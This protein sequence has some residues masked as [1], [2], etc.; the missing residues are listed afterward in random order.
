MASESSASTKASTAPH[1]ED[2]R[3]PGTPTELDGRTWKYVLGKAVSEFSRDQCTLLAAALTYYGVLSLFPALLAVVSLLGVFGQGESTTN[4]ILD[5]INRFGS[6]S[7]AD[8]LEGPISNMVNASGAGIGLV[9]GLLGALWSASGYV[10]AFGKAMNTIY[11]VDEGRPIWKLRPQMLLVTAG[12]VVL[13][14]LLALGLVVSGG[15]ADAIGSVIGLGDT[16]VMVWGI[17]KWPVMLLL[18]VVM[19]ASLYYFTPNVRHPAFR[20]VTPGAAVAIL[21]AILATVA[22]G[23][24]VA[25]FSSYNATYG[26]LAGVI[27]FLLWLWIINTVLLL[28]AEVD[29]E[30]ERGRQLQAGI[31]AEEEIQLPPRDTAAS[32]KAEEKEEESVAKGRKIRMSARHSGRNGRDD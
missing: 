16:A 28:G 17:A 18:V 29:A 7:A 3:K 10:T 13:A 30:I 1:P 21:V 27:I 4:A 5:L 23:F 11:E 8:Q 19:V 12:L 2:D 32:E 20:W 31:E 6:G 26:S 9:V 24:Y 22:F 14:V 25:N 15:V